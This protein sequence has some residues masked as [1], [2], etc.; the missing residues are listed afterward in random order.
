MTETRVPVSSQAR[1]ASLVRF[2]TWHLGLLVLYVAVAIVNIQDQR[3]TESPLIAIASAGFLAY[4]TIGWLGWKYVQRY[5][6]RVGALPLLLLY[7]V[8]LAVFFL[9]A[10]HVYLAIEQLYRGGAF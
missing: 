3:V 4:A 10:T 9:V 8:A 1:F 7:L 2:R 5:E 6:A